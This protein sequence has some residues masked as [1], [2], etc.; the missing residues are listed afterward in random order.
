MCSVPGVS[1]SHAHMYPMYSMFAR[2]GDIMFALIVLNH[3]F[4]A[5]NTSITKKKI[6]C[7][8]FILCNNFNDRSIFLSDSKFYSFRRNC[9][10][11]TKSKEI[12]KFLSL[13]KIPHFQEEL[14]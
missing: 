1:A 2:A 13:K 3:P 5:D 14:N 12:K 7:N 8:T 6:N 11:S 10:I 9:R 4:I